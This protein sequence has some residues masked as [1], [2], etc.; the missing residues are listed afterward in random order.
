MNYDCKCTKNELR[1]QVSEGLDLET[2]GKVRLDLTGAETTMPKRGE[3][4]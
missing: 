4:V 3:G 1:L 2:T